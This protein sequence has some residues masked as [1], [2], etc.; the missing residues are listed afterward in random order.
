MTPCLNKIRCHSF[1][2]NNFCVRAR[3]F[4]IFGMQF[5]KWI[6]V[7][8]RYRCHV[9]HLPGDVMLTSMKCNEIVLFTEKINISPC[10][11]EKRQ[12]SL[13]P[14]MLPPNSSNLNPVDYSVWGI[15]QERIY[16]KNVCWGSGGCW[17]T[18]PSRQWLRSGVVVW[19]HVFVWMV[20][21]LNTGFEPVTLWCI[22][23]V[24][25]ILGLV[26]LIDINTRK[27]LILREMCYFCVWDIYTVR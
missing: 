4:T 20:D 19:V 15:V 9:H 16:H 7:I 14:E 24:L 21:I 10:C 1:F 26:N 6:L 12:S 17:T 13:S 23:F 8:L 27:V 22:L 2:D 25:S 11:R 18:P 5:C 3:I